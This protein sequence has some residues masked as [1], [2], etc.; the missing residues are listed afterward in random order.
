MTTQEAIAAAFKSIETSGADAL[1]GAG[2]DAQAAIDATREYVAQLAPDAEQLLTAAA[3]AAARGEDAGTWTAGLVA[4]TE[5]AALRT[6]QLVE[7]LSEATGRRLADVGH[8]ALNVLLTLLPV[9][10]AAV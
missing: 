6:V 9:L 4:L 8:G 1:K 3:D 7:G 5:A 10:L 2:M